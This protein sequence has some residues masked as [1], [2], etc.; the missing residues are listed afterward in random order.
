M[1]EK[2]DSR[3]KF[4]NIAFFPRLFAAMALRYRANRALFEWN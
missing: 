3:G 1:I 4:A 2:A